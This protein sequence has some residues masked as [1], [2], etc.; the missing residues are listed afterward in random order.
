MK[1]II[2]NILLFVLVLVS[3][4]MLLWPVLQR[5][6]AKV[7]I[8]QATQLFNQGKTLMLD[9]RDETEFAAGHMRDAKNI[10][11]KQL[12]ARLGELDKFKAK[13]VI[14]VCATGVRSSQA[15]AQLKNAGFQDV[16][17]LDGGLTA[18]Q[19][20]GLPTVK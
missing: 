3:G 10:P 2:D 18:W 9:V 1:F 11:L 13:T 12:S 16:H 15:A 19:T 8:L 20:Q 5:R 14:V 7:S 6:G 17:S 4:G